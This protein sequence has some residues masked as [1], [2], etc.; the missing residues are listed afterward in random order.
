MNPD[1]DP[2]YPMPLALAESDPLE[3]AIVAA[4]NGR[5]SH[6]LWR[7]WIDHWGACAECQQKQPNPAEGAGGSRSEHERWVAAY[8]VIVGQLVAAREA[9]QRQQQ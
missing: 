1:G 9:R 4:E 2:D 8:D 3:A 6:V 5:A 7:D